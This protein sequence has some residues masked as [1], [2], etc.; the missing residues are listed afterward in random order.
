VRGDLYANVTPTF[1]TEQLNGGEQ[2]WGVDSDLTDQK[3][4]SFNETRIF[5]TVLTKARH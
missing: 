3:L 4:S 2:P 5:I 1:I